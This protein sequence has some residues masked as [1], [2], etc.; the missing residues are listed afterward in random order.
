MDLLTRYQTRAR[1]RVHT[2]RASYPLVH[3]SSRFANTRGHLLLLAHAQ[4]HYHDAA[5]FTSLLP[6]V[7]LHH[8][9]S[10]IDIITQP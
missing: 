7:E 4:F 9:I 5:E 8:D 2:P 3:R 10:T 1:G 6:I